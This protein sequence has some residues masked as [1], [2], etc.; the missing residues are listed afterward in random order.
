MDEPFSA[1]DTLTAENLRGELLELWLDKTMPARAIFIVTHNIEEA[2]LLSDR[3]IVLG[4]SPTRPGAC[5]RADFYIDLAHPR[6]RKSTRFL[7]LIDYTYKS[8][9]RPM[10][11]HEPGPAES[12]PGNGGAWNASIV[13]EYFHFGGRIL[14][15]T[16]LGATI[17]RATDTGAFDLLLAATI[18]M[19]A[20][21][22]TINRL[23]WRRLYRLAESRYKLEA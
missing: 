2:V 12:A 21:V 17:S 9:T 8:L 13:A 3:I 6:G 1:L 5:V 20:M 16:G 11:Y 18:V 22:V 10:P 4:R 15:T 19:A 7:E 23:V 14:S